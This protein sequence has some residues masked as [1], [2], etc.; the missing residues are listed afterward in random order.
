MPAM[1]PGAP[2][3]NMRPYGQ[4]GWCVMEEAAACIAAFY[5]CDR[6]EMQPK[7]LDISG[8]EPQ[9]HVPKKKPS[10]QTIEAMIDSATFTGKGDKE[11]VMK[12]IKDFN[13]LLNDTDHPLGVVC[14]GA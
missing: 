13:A 7:L 6:D 1:P 2:D 10:I 4:R 9:P 12:Q 3:Y 8:I 14:M 5:G 11:V